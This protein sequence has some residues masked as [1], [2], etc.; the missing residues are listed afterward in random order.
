LQLAIKITL[1]ALH[2]WQLCNPN[3][4][5]GISCSTNYELFTYK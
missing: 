3:H 5:Q 2:Y 1:T 4:P